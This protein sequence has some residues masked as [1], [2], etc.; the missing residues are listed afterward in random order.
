MYLTTLMYF[1]AD[2]SFCAQSFILFC[3]FVG[4]VGIL[5]CHPDLAGKMAAAGALT[6]ESTAEQKVA[7]LDNLSPEE[8]VL[9]DSLNSKYEINIILISVWIKSKL[10]EVDF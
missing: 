1:K 9:L 8:Q 4:H 10:Y 3:W 6:K 5:R 2:L 7:G